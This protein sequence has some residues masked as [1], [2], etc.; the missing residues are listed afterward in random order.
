MRRAVAALVRAAHPAP[1]ADAAPPLAAV[2]LD[3]PSAGMPRAPHAPAPER[4]VV[5][6][7][8]E[9]HRPGVYRLPPASRVDDAV[10]AAGGASSGADPV[11]VNLAER[12]HDGE[13]V[14]VPTRGAVPPPDVGATGSGV[15]TKRHRRSAVAAARG[16]GSHRRS[17]RRARKAPP[18]APIDVNA[19]DAALLETVPGIGPRLAAR[20]V[21]F[22][23]TN[24]RFASADELLDVNGVSERLLDEIAPYVS[25]GSR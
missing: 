22:R 10:R 3:A 5:F 25:F 4:I 21:E 24:G 17:G 6:V 18:D 7:A 14:V 1:T 23:E 12:L 11:A 9:V 19:A 15:A 2:P 8:G 20:I 13:E 16:T